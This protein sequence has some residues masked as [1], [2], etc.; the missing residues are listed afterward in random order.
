VPKAILVVDDDPA[1]AQ[2][3]GELLTETGYTVYLANDAATALTHAAAVK[4]ALVVSDLQMPGFGSGADAARAMRNTPELKS[5][6]IIFLSGLDQPTAQR[7]ISGIPGC[8]FVSKPP[9]LA[10]LAALVRST[11]GAP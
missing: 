4:P 5:T 11:I 6:P 2:V 10:D 8:R 1:F 3:V 7:M 9:V